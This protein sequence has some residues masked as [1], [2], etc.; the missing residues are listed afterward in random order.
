MKHLKKHSLLKYQVDSIDLFS[1]EVM[2][3]LKL[4]PG[5]RY[6]LRKK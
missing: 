4:K 2:K 5:F 3:E 6:R 1:M